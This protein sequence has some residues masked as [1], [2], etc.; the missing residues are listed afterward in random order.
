MSFC[1]RLKPTSR[2]RPRSI[3]IWYWSWFGQKIQFSF[4]A[5]LHT[6]LLLFIHSHAFKSSLFQLLNKY[7][8]ANQLPFGCQF[9]S[10]QNNHRPH[11][12]HNF[13]L[14]EPSRR[15]QTSTVIILNR[16]TARFQIPGRGE[17]PNVGYT[18][19]CQQPGSI[20]HLQKS[21]TGPKFLKFYSRTGP[22][23]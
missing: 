20:F 23:F 11:E 17:L 22:T 10:L 16:N 12:Q 14:L 2:P 13:E 3:K 9:I 21:R 7:V 8:S 1:Q 4:L 15:G 19:M 18:G 6:F 5:S